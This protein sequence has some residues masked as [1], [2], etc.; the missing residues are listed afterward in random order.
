[1]SRYSYY[2]TKCSDPKILVQTLVKMGFNEADI[3]I[4]HGR[5][6][7]GVD[8][9]FRHN[10]DGSVKTA[11]ITIPRDFVGEAANDLG[12][13]KVGEFYEVEI[14]EFDEGYNGYDQDW[15]DQLHQ[16]Y[17]VT[18]LEETFGVEGWQIEQAMAEDG[19]TIQMEISIW[20]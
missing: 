11:D 14:S 13:R 9:E 20:E 1:M 16:T 3:I 12:F 8:D 10:A 4:E 19:T 7:R 18:A 6:L 5:K 2:K 15:K 17:A